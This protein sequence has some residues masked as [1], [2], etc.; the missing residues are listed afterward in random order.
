MSRRGSAGGTQSVVG[1]Y[2]GALL[3]AHHNWAHS[4]RSARKTA[5]EPPTYTG[6]QG[7]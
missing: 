5:R 7:T 6:H 4:G 2:L 1:A 3:W